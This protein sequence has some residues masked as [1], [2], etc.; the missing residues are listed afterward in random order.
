M[1][2]QNKEKSMSQKILEIL[3]GLSTKDAKDIL[4]E[5]YEDLDKYSIVE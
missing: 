1:S 5:L 3:K 2:E 4:V